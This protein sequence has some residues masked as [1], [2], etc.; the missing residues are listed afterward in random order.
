[1][2]L[3]MTS[4]AAWDFR[5]MMA[6]EESIGLAEVDASSS[7]VRG[8]DGFEKLGGPMKVR[9]WYIPEKWTPQAVECIPHPIHT[10]AIETRSNPVDA[11]VRI[12]PNVH[13]I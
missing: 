11:F 12:I 6:D 7:D 1:M 4:A 2:S 13:H 10:L 5:D 8:F 3:T 9:A